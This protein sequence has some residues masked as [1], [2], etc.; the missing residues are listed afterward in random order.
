MYCL[1]PP[2]APPHPPLGVVRT[3][4]GKVLHLHAVVH[5]GAAKVEIDVKEK[6]NVAGVVQDVPRGHEAVVVPVLGKARAKGNEKDAAGSG[7][8]G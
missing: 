2:S 6:E 7:K 1:Q 5:D 3:Y 4:D 8:G